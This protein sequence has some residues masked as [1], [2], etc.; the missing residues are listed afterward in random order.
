M[1]DSYFDLPSQIPVAVGRFSIPDWFLGFRIVDEWGPYA[2]LRCTDRSQSIVIIEKRYARKGDRCYRLDEYCVYDWNVTA[3]VGTV[4]HRLR[5]DQEKIRRAERG[6]ELR[7]HRNTPDGTEDKAEHVLR[8]LRRLSALDGQIVARFNDVRW[9]Q[10]MAR[11]KTF[12]SLEIVEVANADWVSEIPEGQMQRRPE[13]DQWI[14]PVPKEA[15][16]IFDNAFKATEGGEANRFHNCPLEFPAEV[17][18]LLRQR[19]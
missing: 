7:L 12:S 13:H 16:I 5:I 1:S 9:E 18:A 14:E 2:E 4:T 8:E 11:V 6:A 15:A 19:N 17:L 10:E 3:W